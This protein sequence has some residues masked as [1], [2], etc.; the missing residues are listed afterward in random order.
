MQ[1]VVENDTSPADLGDSLTM[2]FQT[3]TRA[4]VGGRRYT[5]RSEALPGHTGFVEKWEQ[6]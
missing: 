2:V 3:G 5:T 6:K 1:I 4:I